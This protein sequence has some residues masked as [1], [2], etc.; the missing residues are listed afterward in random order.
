[1]T[2]TAVVL[3]TP[4]DHLQ[5]GG[6]ASSVANEPG[7]VELNK[8]RYDHTVI[9]ITQLID[10]GHSMQVPL[11]VR[12]DSDAIQTK[13]TRTA[14]QAQ[15]LVDNRPVAVVQRQLAEMMNNS[16][17]VL[18]QRALSGAIHNSPRMLAK[19]HEMNAPFRGAV[20]PP[21]DGA[22][23]ALASPAQCEEK[24]NDI[25]LPDQLKAGIASL[26][27]MRMGHVK[28]HYNSDKPAQLLAHAYAQGSEIHVAPGQERHLPHEARHAVQQVQG[29]VVPTCVSKCVVLN[30]TPEMERE[31]NV[32]V[33]RVAGLS[34]G[35]SGA[36]PPS[37]A[38]K[39]T[40]TG[41]IVQR[42]FRATQVSDLNRVRRYVIA[43][44]PDLAPAFRRIDVAPNEDADLYGWLKENMAVS[45]HDVNDW[46]ARTVRGQ[47]IRLGDEEVR[48]SRD[49]ASDSEDELDSFRIGLDEA[50]YSADELADLHH[51]LRVR[52]APRD[53]DRRHEIVKHTGGRVFANKQDPAK[54]NN[55]VYETGGRVFANEQDPAEHDCLDAAM[56][57]DEDRPFVAPLFL[58][59]DD[60]SDRTDTDGSDTGEDNDYDEND[61][62][63]SRHVARTMNL[64]N[65][66]L[67]EKRLKDLYKASKKYAKSKLKD[68][69]SPS[70]Q[71]TR[72]AVMF[73]KGMRPK[74]KLFRKT[75]KFRH[76]GVNVGN[77]AKLPDE[78]TNE[79][80]RDLATLNALLSL[81]VPIA[82]AEQ[83]VDSRFVVAQ[84]RGLSYSRKTFTKPKRALHRRL[85]ETNRAVF[86][87]AA[88]ESSPL[89]VA[90][91]YYLYGAGGRQDAFNAYL[92]LVDAQAQKIRRALLSL[93]SRP[94]CEDAREAVG[95]ATDNFKPRSLADIGT[96]FYSQNYDG[97]H[98]SLAKSLEPQDVG[99]APS[100]LAPL[101]AGLTSPGNPKVST[102]D[103]PTHAAR[104]AYGIKAYKGHEADVLEP[105]YNS[106][107]VPRHPY[108]G[109][110][111]VSIHPLS[112]Y[113]AE[114]PEQ[115][116][117]LQRQGR[118]NIGKV[119]LPERET[120]FEGM[121][122]PDRVKH[123][124][125]AK[126]PNFHKPYK[127][128][129][130]RKYGLSRNLFGSFRKG[131]RN[132]RPG[133]DERIYVEA[134]LSNY[135]AMHAELSLIEKASSLA[136]VQG[137]GLVYRTG[138]NSF[139]FEPPSLNGS[140]SSTSPQEWTGVKELLFPGMTQSKVSKN[141]S[142][143][144]NVIRISGAGFACYI[145]SLVTAAARFHNVIDPAAIEEM[146]NAVQD[147]LGSVGLRRA[148]EDID[149]GGLVAAEVRRV[150]A[151]LLNGFNPQVHIV[152]QGAD[153]LTT[154]VANGGNTKV[155]LYYTPGHFD[156]LPGPV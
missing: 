55:I 146:V 120:P 44:R 70:N 14:T 133:S 141:A 153:G 65:P 71:D 145:R 79:Q 150:L 27:G 31:A 140:S 122:G 61:G 148:G 56:S 58:D 62:F 66:H 124:T 93:R 112:D 130:A 47:H 64:L 60:D 1:M 43:L 30:N 87:L 68:P 52:D 2:S 9:S 110:V 39:F 97:Y 25:G 107:R 144:E 106:S 7:L 72:P 50:D 19:R 101:F 67:T 6:K 42:F 34:P 102:G 142:T 138:A 15:R 151:D 49:I 11:Q 13:T 121:L 156:L 23:P 40:Q 29:N 53:R 88:L 135:L 16:Q 8:W 46:D 137:A 35:S 105:D 5:E 91:F 12:S 128:V 123:R 86:S 95:R 59:S 152:T 99:A 77:R 24:I 103:V 100:P 63:A 104:Y 81:D 57:N 80:M 74:G 113:G 22:M 48:G 126:F 111:Y 96:H 38:R 76:P 20:R 108:S 117:E 54:H 73:E 26:F 109:Q 3:T 155:Y 36:P 85:D 75:A 51:L 10:I 78:P 114:G 98:K 125:A 33:E 89:G 154:Y 83:L 139:G 32:I 4:R 136:H 134:L 94:P 84:Y 18:Q 149:A 131:L 143:P 116:S 92:S 115:L 118:I 45:I 127:P 41:T 17:R 147:H 119:I 82:L 21:G 129:Y 28:V 37:H 132:T 69:Q 90:V